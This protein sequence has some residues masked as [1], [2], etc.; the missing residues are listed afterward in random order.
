MKTESDIII[1]GAGVSGLSAAS[2]LSSKGKKVILI[3]ARDRTGGR[4]ETHAGKF[5]NILRAGPEFVHGDLPLTKSLLKKA[6]GTIY[7]QEGEMYRSQKGQIFPVKD[8]APGMKEFMK[9]L[10]DLENDKT[11]KDFLN[12][13]FKEKKY[14][15]LRKSITRMAEGFD[16]ADT[17]RISARAIYEEWSGDSLEASHLV[18][19]SYGVIVSELTSQCI[20]NGCEVLL[21]KEVKKI[22][23]EK[24]S[25]KIH[26]KDR[27]SYS[28]KQVLV[29]LPL[30]ILTSDK[31]TKGYIQFS[32]AIPR[33]IKA[34]KSMGYGP[35]VK[36]LME[37]TSRFWNDER[38]RNEVQQFPD[39]GFLLNETDFPTLWFSNKD[40]VP[41][42]TAWAGGGRAKKLQELNTSK[43]KAK[44][45]ASVAE[46]FNCPVSFL[47]KNIAGISVFNWA[48]ENYSKGAYSYETPQSK[49]AKLVLREPLK[50]TLF[51]CGEALGKTT[52]TLEAAL[53]SAE[54]VVKEL[55]K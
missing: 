30:G 32:P 35:V 33:K 52:G 48:K 31:K 53:E 14:K 45:I 36:V 16:V 20:N 29:T 11:L 15:E 49:E 43:L 22:D 17:N 6:G 5:G 51:F 25:V 13:N 1:I 38:F 23:W 3:E 37:L 41:L 44:S 12:A 42:I 19:E 46:A 2:Q 39:L 34:A 55:L 26:C 4:V 40:E 50:N 8:Y 7:E 54:W 24:G 28:A 21:S 18:K 47:K 10:K 27:T 9:K